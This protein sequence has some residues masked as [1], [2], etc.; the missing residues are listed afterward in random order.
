[1]FLLETENCLRNDVALNLVR[2]AIDGGLAHVEV[3]AR[4][5]QSVIG[6]NGV[7]VVA[8]RLMVGIAVIAD[9][10]DRELRDPL[11]NLGALDFENRAFG[12]GMSA[13]GFRR[14]RAQ[15]RI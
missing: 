12:A 10:F 1:M 15:F 8:E 3:T 4:L 9:R 13:F 2:P 7:F 6:T 14:Q 5:T 11:L